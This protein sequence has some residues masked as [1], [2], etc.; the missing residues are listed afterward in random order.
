MEK[1]I[2][3]TN[4]ENEE[5]NWSKEAILCL[6]KAYKEEPCLYAVNTAHYYNKYLRNKAL[7]KVCAAVS[8]FKPGIT[9]SMC[10]AKFQNLRNQFYQFNE[11][12]KM[13]ASITKSGTSTDD[14]SMKI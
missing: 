9:E 3:I 7:K 14:V 12:A 11:N 5:E 10:A 2:I 13:K 1:N 4:K 8:V 6:I